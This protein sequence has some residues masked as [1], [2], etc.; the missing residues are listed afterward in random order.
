MEGGYCKMANDDKLI[1]LVTR[2]HA[3]RVKVLLS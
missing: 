3:A 2:A 1:D